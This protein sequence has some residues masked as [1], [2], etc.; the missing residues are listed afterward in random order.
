M[1]IEKMPLKICFELSNTLESELPLPKVTI[2]LDDL[3]L[4]KDVEL[5]N[6]NNETAVWQTNKKISIKKYN[7]DFDDNEQKEHTITII[8][9]ASFPKISSDQDYGV[10]IK[11]I[12]INEISVEALVWRKGLVRSELCPESEYSTNGFINYAK[13]HMIEILDEISVINEKCVWQSHGDFINFNMDHYEYSFKFST[14]LYIW[15]LEEL[16]QQ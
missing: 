4:D 11:D 10:F 6:I 3:I 9:P 14:P 8:K 7:V 1:T 15:L 12:Q 16:L 2:K 13:N 5:N